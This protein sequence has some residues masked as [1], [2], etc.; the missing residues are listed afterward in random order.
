VP[1]VDTKKRPVSPASSPARTGPADALFSKVQQRVLGVLFGNSDRSFYAK[2]IIGLASSG[3]GAV[4]R[5][6]ARLVASG[7]VTV[8]QVGKQKHHQANPDSPLF[9]ELRVLALKS[10]AL[11]DVLRDRANGTVSRLSHL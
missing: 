6:L 9:S 5:E 2:E 3:S 10:F 1:N 4:Q 11:G 7:L 8:S